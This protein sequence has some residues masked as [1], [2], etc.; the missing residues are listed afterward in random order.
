MAYVATMKPYMLMILYD[1]DAQDPRKDSE[2]FGNMLCWHNKYNLGDDGKDGRS[3]ESFLE[4][5]VFENQ[6]SDSIINEAHRGLYIKIDY[7]KTNKG[8]NV[9]NREKITEDFRGQEFVEGKMEDIKD[10]LAVSIVQAMNSSQL[11]TLIE[12]NNVILP[13]YLYDHS[14]ITMNT[15]GFSCKWDSGQVGWI[16]ASHK[17]IKEEYGAI[18]PE[19]IERSEQLLISEVKS[20]DD[21]LTGENYGFKLFKDGEETD[22]CWGFLGNIEDIKETIA[23]HLPDH[24]KTL[25]DDLEYLNENETQSYEN[26]YEEEFEEMEDCR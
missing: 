3:P 11:F 26:D 1:E 2:P 9:S 13:L 4:D 15:T 16:Y 8:Y 5:L 22:S 10:E 19:T 23:G 21:Y 6:S 7:D 24:C 20:Y 25:V 12:K 18:T 14:G 17:E